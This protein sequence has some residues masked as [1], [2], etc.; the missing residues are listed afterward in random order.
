MLNLLNLSDLYMGSASDKVTLRSGLLDHLKPGDLIV[1]DNGFT[2]QAI[3][4]DGVHLNIPPRLMHP[5]FTPSENQLTTDIARARI[6]VE[7]A[8]ERVEGFHTFTHVPHHLRSSI[9]TIFQV[10]AWLVNLQKPA[11]LKESRASTFSHMCPTI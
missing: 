2:I 11:L 3:L 10:C 6:H 9:T 4:P 7:R 8:I 1:A 5:Q